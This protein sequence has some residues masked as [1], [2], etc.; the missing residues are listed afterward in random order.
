MDSRWELSRKGAKYE[1]RRH[2]REGRCGFAFFI[3]NVGL[4]VALGLRTTRTRL[5]INYYIV[6]C[7]S[8][9]SVA[10]LARENCQARSAELRL[11]VAIC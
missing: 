7:C 10:G 6:S 1:V 2:G 5:W 8:R 3:I 11:S 4:P 9:P